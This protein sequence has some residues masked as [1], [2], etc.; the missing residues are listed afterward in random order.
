MIHQIFQRDI[1]SYEESF[2]IGA[3]CFLSDESD[4]VYFLPLGNRGYVRLL[5]TKRRSV[6]GHQILRV[7]PATSDG[8]GRIQT[9]VREREREL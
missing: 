5:F 7:E 6:N 9:M 2:Y 4:G 1:K 3:C 8:L